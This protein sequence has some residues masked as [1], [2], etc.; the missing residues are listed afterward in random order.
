MG[1]FLELF[2]RKVQLTKGKCSCTAGLMGSLC[3]GHLMRF[4]KILRRAEQHTCRISNCPTGVTLTKT[5]G[6]NQLLKIR[7]ALIV[8]VKDP[9]PGLWNLQVTGDGAHTVRVTGLSGLD[10]VHGFSRNVTLDLRFTHH[11]PIKGRK[12]REVGRSLLW[13]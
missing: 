6:L 1:H 10:F 8:N 13:K 5:N 3:C 7:K 2:F 12:P 9:T 11:R 4:I